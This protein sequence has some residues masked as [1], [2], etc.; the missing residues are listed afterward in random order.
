MSDQNQ[1][2]KGLSLPVKMLIGMLLGV[3]AGFALGDKVTYISFVGEIFMRLLKMCIYPLVLISIIGGV[4]NVVDVARLK[5]V[6]ISFLLYSAI[7]AFLLA[8]ITVAVMT[9]V[10]AGKGV[11]LGREGSGT[12]PADILS[13]V[14]NWVPN[15]FFT[16]LAEGNL[17]QIIVFAV[18]FGIMLVS[19]RDTKQGAAILELVRG[20]DTIMAKMVGAVIKLAPYGVFALMANMVGN[21]E[22]S[23]MVGFSKMIITYYAVI[24]VFLLIIAPLILRFIAKV[25]PVRFYKNVFPTMVMAAST[26]SSVGTIPVTMHTTKYR[27]GVPVDI[28]EMLTAPAAT[29]NMTG[30]AAEYACFVLFAA[31]V[32]DVALTPEQIF[33][34][35]LLCVIMSAGAAGV[36][37]GGIMMCAICLNTMGLPDKEMVAIV[38]GLYVLIDFAS[39]MTNVTSDTIGMVTVSGIVGDL[40]RET[41]NAKKVD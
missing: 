14:I 37:G 34:T 40:D 39:T 35:I 32:F 36:P 13:M 25:S 31:N 3:A 33:L 9:W 38:A 28:V 1:N 4:A 27:C 29:I 7:N 5:K 18:F 19:I 26:C 17:V 20:L 24:A 21:A 41:F 11:V 22:I 15:N 10:G 12:P 16:S 8:G 6:G 2:K 30:A 23:V